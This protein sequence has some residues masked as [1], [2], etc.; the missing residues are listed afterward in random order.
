MTD[1]RLFYGAAM[2][3]T[4]EFMFALMGATIRHLSV[5]L[6][7]AT[8]VFARNLV[9]LA[10]LL[11]LSARTGIGELA[12]R[13]PSLHL[14]RGLAGTGAMYCF[15]YAIAN[16]PLAD[17]MLLKLTAPLFMPL[18][19][20]FWLKERF[21]WHVL[22]ALGVGF[23]GVGLILSPDL[24]Q[25]QPVAL[26]A[27]L[28]GVLAAVAK[29]TVRRLS[30][31]E[32]ATRIVFYFAA[33]GT[34]VSLVPLAWWGQSPG[35]A[36][37]AWFLVLG[38][39]ATGGQFLLTRGMASAP[40]ARLAPFTFFSVV[41]GALL[42]WLLWDELLRWTTLAGALL[43]LVAALVVSRGRAPAQRAPGR[44]A[45]APSPL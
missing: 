21:T 39:C 37:L 2:I 35:P 44:V 10:I 1:N 45:D 12:T 7:N 15:F 19:A 11:A 31:S 30:A 23:A 9:G 32:P 16:M 18:V 42:G 33:I 29:V 13:V 43:V 27:L 34:A 5:D 4:A 14:L 41:F 40:A 25:L 6:D 26:I 28:G 22:A 17:A 38:A 8:I 36:H 24:G 3:I 20:L